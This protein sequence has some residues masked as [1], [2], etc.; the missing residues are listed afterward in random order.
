MLQALALVRQ[1][2]L[3]GRAVESDVKTLQRVLGD[4]RPVA[5]EDRLTPAWRKLCQAKP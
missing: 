2:A 4:Y 5:A 3:P 1:P